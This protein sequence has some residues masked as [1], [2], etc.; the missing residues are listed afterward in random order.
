MQ[1]K[2]TS[3]IQKTI[4]NNLFELSK[5]TLENYIESIYIDD[6]G[7]QNIKCHILNS[8]T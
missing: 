7:V 8:A 5:G 4:N 2:K 3:G 1:N 6:E